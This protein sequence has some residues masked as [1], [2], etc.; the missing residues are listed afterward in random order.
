M[1]DHVVILDTAML[2]WDVRLSAHL[3]TLEVRVSDVPATTDET[4]L[5]AALV[6]ALV[7]TALGAID[8]GQP[9]PVLDP[10]LL[11]AAYWRAARDGVTG[12][13]VDTGSGHLVPA[14][15]ATARLV[16]HVRPALERT[17][18][19]RTVH[20]AVECVL[21]AGNGAV[22]QRRTLQAGT[23]ADLLRVLTRPTPDSCASTE[24]LGH[25]T[26]DRS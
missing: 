7:T 13:A 21:G 14:R 20:C 10:A 8:R 5:L 22:R 1:L 15:E 16:D 9:V 12:Y 23:L 26:A 11:R 4:V 18:D 2:Y 17:G 19:Y 3:P 6:R 24:E 25:G